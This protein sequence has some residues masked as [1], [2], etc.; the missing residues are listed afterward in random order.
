LGLKGLLEPEFHVDGMVADGRTL[1]AV[2]AMSQ[3]DI[4]ILEVDLPFLNGLDA[5]VRIKTARHETKL[6]YLTG[7]PR[8]ALAAAAFQRGA[9][10]YVL[11]QDRAEE[12]LIA[13]RRVIR[14]EVY[15]TS[16]LN[17][18]EIELYRRLGLAVARN[19]TARQ[20]EILKLLAEGK[21]MKEIADILRIKPA[22]VTFHKHRIM[23]RLKIKTSTG[24]CEYAIKEGIHA[25]GP[26]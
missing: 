2:A 5:G 8:A 17:K 1:V 9:S 22:S 25:K 6:I 3:P 21:P 4:V 23:E 19:L 13:V 20:I 14:G 15:L 7:V 12:I 16:L 18:N 11:K 24:L 10:G 26:D